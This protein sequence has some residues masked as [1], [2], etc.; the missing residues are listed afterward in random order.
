[1]TDLHQPMAKS[2]LPLQRLDVFTSTSGYAL[3]SI[4]GVSRVGLDERFGLE[5]T[6]LSGGLNVI[7]SF[8]V[9]GVWLLSCGAL[10]SG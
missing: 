8:K 5:E 3:L 1:M 2:A 7:L 4:I 9:S 6:R 10:C